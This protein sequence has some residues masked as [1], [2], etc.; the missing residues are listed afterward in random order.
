MN[1][2]DVLHEEHEQVDGLFQAI[3]SAQSDEDKNALVAELVDALSKHT[4]AEEQ[5]VYVTLND[6]DLIGHATEEHREA[7]AMLRKLGGT[8]PGRPNFDSYLAALEESVKHHVHEEETL[9]FD[10]LREIH[11]DARLAELAEEFEA[12]KG[13]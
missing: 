1:I 11:D 8:A 4:R 13:E 12:A 3:K 6:P 9:I 2:L 10:E 7:D 5:V